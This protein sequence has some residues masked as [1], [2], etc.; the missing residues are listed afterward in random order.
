MKRRNS[1]I[2]QRLR[3]T[4]FHWARAKKKKKKTSDWRRQETKDVST[5]S[6]STYKFANKARESKMPVG[7]SVRSLPPR[8]LRAARNEIDQMFKIGS[9]S[10][11]I[12]HYHYSFDFNPP[13]QQVALL[14]AAKSPKL[15]Y[16]AEA[17]SSCI[18]LGQGERRRRRRKHHAQGGR[19]QKI[20]PQLAKVRTKK[21]A[22]TGS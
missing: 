17:Q 20:S 1:S 13:H 16:R 15:I 5:T 6:E 22:R 14:N 4:S 8:P 3:Q 10:C 19:K 9:I 12:T 18:S 2:E 11:P 7:S 21:P